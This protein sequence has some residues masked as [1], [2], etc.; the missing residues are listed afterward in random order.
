VLSG[1]EKGVS[2]SDKAG[3]EATPDEMTVALEEL[4]PHLKTRIPKPCK[5]A[6]AKIRELKWAPACCMEV[7]DLERLIK[8][9]KFKDALP[10]VEAL[11]S[12]LKG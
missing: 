7:A 4:V 8:K 6:M 3:P 2:G 5:A 12:R 10:L 9:Y 11:Q 1:E